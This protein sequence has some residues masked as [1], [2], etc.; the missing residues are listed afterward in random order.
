MRSDLIYAANDS[1]LQENVRAAEDILQCFIRRIMSDV[2]PYNNV[3]SKCKCSVLYIILEAFGIS[4]KFLKVR[5][6]TII[7]FPLH[8]R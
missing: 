6:V 4:L 2:S 3:Q 7:L 5:R 1:D 8:N